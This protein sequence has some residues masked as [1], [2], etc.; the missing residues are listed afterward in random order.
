MTKNNAIIPPFMDSGDYLV[1]LPSAAAPAREV[2]EE[3]LHRTP[4]WLGHMIDAAA[5]AQRYI[6]TVRPNR[7]KSK[8]VSVYRSKI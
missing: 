1:D 4:Y 8:R 2:S 6:Q 5:A 3:E 7:R